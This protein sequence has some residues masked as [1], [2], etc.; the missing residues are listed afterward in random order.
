MLPSKPGRH[1]SHCSVHDYED[2]DYLGALESSEVRNLKE[3]ID[4][5]KAHADIEMPYGER[6]TVLLGDASTDLTQI[7]QIKGD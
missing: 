7:T 6:P 4:W 3:L 5:N 1:G 2:N